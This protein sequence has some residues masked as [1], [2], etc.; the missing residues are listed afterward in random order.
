MEPLARRLTALDT[1]ARSLRNY[2]INVDQDID[3]LVASAA[4][5]RRSD[6]AREAALLREADRLR[7]QSR[8]ER[9]EIFR[10]DQEMAQ[11]RNQGAA[12]EARL[13]DAK[14]RLQAEVGRVNAEG[15]KLA[16]TEKGLKAV[17]RQVNEPV[18]GSNTRVRA[19]AAR[20]NSLSTYEEF[21]LDLEKQRLLESLR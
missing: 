6:P 20:L 10:V 3:R 7:F 21:T 12:L 19:T 16:R 1:R 5:E 13:R 18:T 9:D 17:E 15:S 4:L 8:D 14:A 11:V 2:L